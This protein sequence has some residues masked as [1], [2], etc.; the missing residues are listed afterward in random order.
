M[1]AVESHGSNMRRFS[2]APLNGPAPPYGRGAGRGVRG[3]GSAQD[4]FIGKGGGMEREVTEGGAVV[5]VGKTVEIT[6]GESMALERCADE[7]RHLSRSGHRGWFLAYMRAHK[8][9]HQ[10]IRTIITRSH[11]N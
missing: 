6:T 11:A 10:V 4:R 1:A 3:G 7:M 8:E 9:S 2:P 5:Q